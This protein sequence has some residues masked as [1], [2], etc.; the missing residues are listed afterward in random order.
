[1]ATVSGRI[2]TSIRRVHSAA[3]REAEA[4]GGL[5]TGATGIALMVLAMLLFTCMDTIGKALTATQPVQ[6]VVWGRY[7][8]SA[9]WMAA[10][11]PVLGWRRLIVT[12]YPLLQLSRGLLIVLATLAIFMAFAVMPL[13]DVYTITFIAPLLITLLSIPL[14]GEKVGWR[15]WTAVVVGFAGVLIV[16]R[17]GTGAMQG[18]ALWPLLTAL[19][20]ASYQLLTRRL[21]GDVRESPSAMAFWMAVV[22]AL[23]TS[24]IVPFT[25]APL[26]PGTVFWLLVMGALG[27]A[28]HLILI[29]ALTRAAASALAPFNYTQLIFAVALGWLVF[30]D[31][32][33]AYTV[34]GGTVIIASGLFV[35]HRSR[36]RGQA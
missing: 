4:R 31:L 10:L 7:L 1:M 11:I 21:S 8:S 20:F 33:D 36:V 3:A 29:L 13:A 22:G 14:L 15:R 17:P 34:L 32:P 35:L 30:G 19:G 26:A 27:A 16:I 23:V 6:Q 18:A 25:W 5:A 24:A 28:G 9:L 2:G 12:R